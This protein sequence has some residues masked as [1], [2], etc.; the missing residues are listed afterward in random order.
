MRFL[1]QDI[2]RNVFTVANNRATMAMAPICLASATLAD[3]RHTVR[4]RN[5]IPEQPSPGW[6]QHPHAT[7]AVVQDRD[8]F[9]SFYNG[10]NSAAFLS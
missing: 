1:K 7:K 6:A 9:S 2:L 8:L 10:E 4:Q 5:R 3:R